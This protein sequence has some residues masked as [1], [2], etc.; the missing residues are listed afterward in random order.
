M[1]T[2]LYASVEEFV[3]LAMTSYQNKMFPN[4]NPHLVQGGGFYLGY[5]RL[6][7]THEAL[8]SQWGA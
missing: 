1:G 4:K 2:L 6:F 7:N 8:N 5:G 3:K